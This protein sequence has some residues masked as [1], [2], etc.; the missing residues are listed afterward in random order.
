MSIAQ[1][2]SSRIKGPHVIF[3]SMGFTFLLG[4]IGV[5]IFF[6]VLNGLK[7]VLDQTLMAPI[8]Y[9]LM[10]S[11]ISFGMG[12]HLKETG[13]DLTNYRNWVVGLVIIGII[14]GIVTGF[15]MW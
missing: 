6:F 8:F 3:E 4:I 9:L 10:M 12:S 14:G 5:F 15:F 1:K 13:N 11:G 7:F 2:S